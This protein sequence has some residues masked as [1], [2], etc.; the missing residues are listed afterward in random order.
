MLRARELKSLNRYDISE[1]KVQ[2][3]K[4][5]LFKESE[6]APNSENDCKNTKF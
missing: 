3:F 5:H 2:N 6:P 1:T 4:P